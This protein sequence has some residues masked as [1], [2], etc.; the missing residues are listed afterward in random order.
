LIG[1]LKL[2]EKENKLKMNKKEKILIL[3]GGKNEEHEISLK[4]AMEAY[5]ALL[6]LGYNAELFNVNPKTFKEKIKNIKTDYC[7][8]ALHGPFGEDG[9]I[10]NILF[11]QNIPFTHSGISASAKAFDKQKTKI[12]LNK[13]DLNLL[14]SQVIS[15]KNINNEFFEELLSKFKSFV[16]KPLSSGSSY[17]VLI[18]KSKS[19][20]NKILKNNKVRDVLYKKHKKLIVEPYIEGRE[21]T[22]SVIEKNNGS[23]PVEVTEILTKKKF[24]DYKAKYTKGFSKHVIPANLEKNIYEDCLIHAKIAH[25]V[26]GCNGATRSDF[27]FDEKNKKIYF[28]EINTQPGLTPISLVPEQLNYKGIGFLEL[29]KLLINLAECRK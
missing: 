23:E 11:D 3:Q 19:D 16:I 15:K 8:N 28:L 21:L 27:I 29:I 12:C 20:I 10:Q 1:K 13:T 22:V 18:I 17:G 9:Q 24:F 5:K 26:I 7:F 6:K 2:L 25:D 4:T 14:E